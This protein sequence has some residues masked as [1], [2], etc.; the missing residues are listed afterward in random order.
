M[1][2]DRVF[3][4][5]GMDNFDAWLEWAHGLFAL[6]RGELADGRGHAV[7]ALEISNRIGDVLIAT[8]G[9]LLVASADLWLE[10]RLAAPIVYSAYDRDASRTDLGFWAR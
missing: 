1:I 4:D 9:E 5:Q 8:W 7:S 2:A 10:D 6:G 3:R